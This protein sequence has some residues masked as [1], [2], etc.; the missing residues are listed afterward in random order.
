MGVGGGKMGKK[1][2]APLENG[3]TAFLL[4]R[5]SGQ[6]LWYQLIFWEA[7]MAR[8]SMTNTP[9]LPTSRA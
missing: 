1:A 2:V 3:A 7:N 4:N 5:Q 9:R 6:S 8:A